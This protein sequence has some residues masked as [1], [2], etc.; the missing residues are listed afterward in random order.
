M[1]YRDGGM[2][3]NNSNGESRGSSISNCFG[4]ILFFLPLVVVFTI[5]IL[6]IVA[7]IFSIRILILDLAIKVINAPDKYEFIKA[8]ASMIEFGLFIAMTYVITLGLYTSLI[9]PLIIEKHIDLGQV[10]KDLTEKVNW[11]FLGMIISILAIYVLEIATKIIQS[12]DD[13]HYNIMTMISFAIVAVIISIIM[14][15]EK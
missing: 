4:V 10:G 9:K 11:P 7:I 2:A 14:R 15:L 8:L 6:W 3:K 5:V 13:L 1:V 12:S